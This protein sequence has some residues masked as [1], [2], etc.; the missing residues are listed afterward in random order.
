MN[1][2]RLLLLMGLSVLPVQAHSVFSVFTRI[3]FR[4]DTLT[5]NAAFIIPEIAQQLNLSPDPHTGRVELP[6][7]QKQRERIV[8][9]F[10]ER[11]QLRVNYFPVEPALIELGL[12]TNPLE[13]RLVTL[14]LQQ[15]GIASPKVLSLAADFTNAVYA[16]YECLVRINYEGKI[17]QVALS[18]EEARATIALSEEGPD[19]FLQ[20]RSFLLL[21]IEHIF[22]G[23]DHILFLIGLIILGGRFLDLVKI[24]TA[25]TLAHSLTLSLAA[26]EWVTLPPAFI[27]SAIALTIVYVAVENF[28]LTHLRYRWAITG[29]FGLVHGFGFANVLRSLGLPKSGLVTSLLSFNIGVEIGQIVIVSLAMPLIWLIHRSAYRRPV[30][31]LVSGVIFWFGFSWF[32]ER[33]FHLTLF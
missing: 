31:W 4:G 16:S 26:L 20:F 22:I 18:G 11:W 10:R 25:F 23:F 32:L 7:L 8:G 1:P 2:R 28:F 30:V 21:G 12:S 27:E 6:E 33:T 24:V 19:R 17:W 13:E 3:D 5:V 9:F 15:T 29:M 14:T